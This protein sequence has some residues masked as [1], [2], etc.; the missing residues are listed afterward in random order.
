MIS[1]ESRV[2]DFELSVRKY[3]VDT[4]ETIEHLKLF[5]DWIEDVPIDALGNKLT[6][7]VI[8]HFNDV[9]FGSVSECLVDINVFTRNDFEND[10][11]NVLTDKVNNYIL[12][13]N[14]D[15]GYHIIP[16]YNTKETPWVFN[17]GIIPFIR[18]IFPVED[19]KDSTKIRTIHIMCKWG[20][21]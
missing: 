5:F 10:L 16:Y 14:A 3:F 6:Q 19:A 2:T 8:I 18:N 21:K 17:G 9:D 4:L 7:W 20:G 13:E 1:P 15:G 12:D 11:N